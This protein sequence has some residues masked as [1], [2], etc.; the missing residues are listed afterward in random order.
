MQS[1]GT[2]QIA[3]L[4]GVSDAIVRSMVRARYVTPARSERGALRFSFRDLVVLRAARELRAAQVPSRRIGSALRALHAQLPE[5]VPAGGLSVAAVGDRVVVRE[6]GVARDPRSGQLLLGFE[7]RVEQGQVRLL[8]ADAGEEAC[9]RAFQAALALEDSDPAAAIAAYQAC[10]A[11][12]GN[13]A[14]RA[15]LGRL[16]H[17]QGRALEAVAT[18]RAVE[19]PD[20]VVSFNLGV[21]LQ[22]LGRDAEAIESYRAALAI[23]ETLADAHHNLAQLLLDRGERQLA[24]RHLGRYRRLRP[25]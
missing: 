21:A 25:R 2:A 15:N 18:Y 16:L 7:V 10:V 22:D 3:R 1:F 12:H 17:L 4:V 11:R 20:A 8:D 6:A 24:L 19:V 13:A 5:E 23:D 14:A 9:E